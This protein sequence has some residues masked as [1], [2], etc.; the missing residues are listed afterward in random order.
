MSKCTFW[1]SVLS[2]L[3]GQLG[4]ESRFH[5]LNAPFGARCF[6]TLNGLEWDGVPRLGLKAP[7]G[8][9][10]FLTPTRKKLQLDNFD[11]LMHR[12][13][14][15]AFSPTRS[16]RSTGITRSLNAPFG[17]RCFLTPYPPLRGLRD[18]VLMHR[19][20]LGAF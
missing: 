15:G 17:A 12:L 7:F 19:L 1:R 5:R 3:R 9:R 14:L 18:T 2:D 11:V 6:R 20:A 8:T 13:A 4:R 10:C 16:P